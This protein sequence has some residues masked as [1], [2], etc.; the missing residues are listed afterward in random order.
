MSGCLP[1]TQEEIDL[2]LNTLES[3]PRNLVLFYLGLTTGFRISELLSL[4]VTD[5]ANPDGS[6][7]DF[8][9]VTRSNMKGKTKSRSTPLLDI[10][11]PHLKQLVLSTS[12]QGKT[13]LFTSRQGGD[14]PIDVSQG[15]RVLSKASH[16]SGVWGTGTHRMRKTF[17]LRIYEANNKNIY[18][19]QKALGHKSIDSTTH[20]L[21]FDREELDDKIRGLF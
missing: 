14:R 4:K 3:N 11:T 19:T 15:W 16:R 17:A 5:V 21:S 8:I 1:Y 6:L 7:K 18:E 20:Y 12:V 2:I 9:K 13:Y 10:V